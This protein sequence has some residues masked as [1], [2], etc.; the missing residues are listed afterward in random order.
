MSWLLLFAIPAVAMPV[1]VTT[2]FLVLS[3][4]FT[5]VPDVVVDGLLA[6][7]IREQPSYSGD[8]QVCAVH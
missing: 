1:A 7:K 8:L 3:S 6:N 5:A 2:A 4:L